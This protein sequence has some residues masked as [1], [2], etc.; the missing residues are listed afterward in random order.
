MAPSS[1]T[2]PFPIL[3]PVLPF[4]AGGGSRSGLKGEGAFSLSRESSPGGM[5]EEDYNEDDRAGGEEQEE[6]DAGGG[7]SGRGHGK[8]NSRRG[9][10]SRSPSADDVVVLLDGGGNRFGRFRFAALRLVHLS[11]PLLNATL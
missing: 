10:S 5:E 3:L 4:P 1:S 6:E 11:C 2:V 9:R 7:K 8:S